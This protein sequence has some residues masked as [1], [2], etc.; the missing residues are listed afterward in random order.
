MNST[1]L[2]VAA[3]LGLIGFGIWI[4]VRI[5]EMSQTLIRIE[6]HAQERVR[7]MV[8]QQRED[9]ILRWSAFALKVAQFLAWAYLSL[10]AAS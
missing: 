5:E 10:L 1:A 9:R 4:Y 8:R 6:N 3:W 2:K 7:L